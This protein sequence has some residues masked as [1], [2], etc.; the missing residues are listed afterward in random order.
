MAENFLI[1]EI[2]NTFSLT[3]KM[4]SR[5]IV[6]NIIV[7]LVLRMISLFAFLSAS[8]FNVQHFISYPYFILALP[9]GLSNLLYHPWTIITYGFTHFE[10]FH[11]IFNMLWLF[12]IGSILT[13]FLGNKKILPVYMMGSWFGG[14]L[15]ILFYNIFPYFNNVVD[16][17]SCIG[18]S[19]G[20]MAIIVA[21]AVLIPDYTIMLFIWSI[22]LKWLAAIFVGIDI[23]SI[24]FSGNAGGHIAHLGGALFGYIYIASYRNGN[25]LSLWFNKAADAIVS[26]FSGRKKMQVTYT[27]TEAKPSVRK[28]E[29]DKQ[30]KID[31]ILD[32]ISKSGYES[33]SAEEKEIL[34]KESRN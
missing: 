8:D 21:A 20:I 30:K 4:V 22:R 16:Q 5:L 10:L 28:K 27:R 12:W 23:I 25:D 2:K 3:G 14:G 34:F 29:I 26:V 17:S 7:F 6:V 11:L 33:L 24:N 18:A 15:Y 31:S 32:K 1:R 13:D 9:S 19:A